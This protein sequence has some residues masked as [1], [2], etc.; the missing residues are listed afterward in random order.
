MKQ[1]K[2]VVKKQT[3]KHESGRSMI[4]MVG[5]LAVMGL[6]TAGAF[7]LITSAMSSQ[8]ISRVDDDVSAIVQGVRLLYNPSDN[9]AGVGGT[10][11]KGADT[12][13]VLG[14]K[15]TKN[16]YGGSYEVNSADVAV[17]YDTTTGAVTNSGTATTSSAAKFSVT[18]TGV[19]KSVCASLKARNW[20][21]GGV[22]NQTNT[23][24]SN[25]AAASNKV[26]IEY[27]KVDRS[28]NQ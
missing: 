18:I 8:R 7:V 24:C 2:K 1:T 9:F 6:I 11:G 20:P 15:D 5:V 10:D 28:A 26:V 27:G 23:V 21:G 25:D 17:T 12:L 13:K 3:K 19:G 4:E 16:P 14:Y 22:V